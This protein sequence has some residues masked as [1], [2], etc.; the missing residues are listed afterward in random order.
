MIHIAPLNDTHEHILEGASCPCEPRIIADPDSEM[1]VV[2]NS[3]DGRE[4]V[5][6][7]NE[8]LNN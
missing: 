7:A 6:W 1:I 3:F 2:H 5:E 8:I 4:G